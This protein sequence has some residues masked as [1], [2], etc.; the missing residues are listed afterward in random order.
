MVEDRDFFKSYIYGARW[1]VDDPTPILE[2]TEDDRLRVA[3]KL[4][5]SPEFNQQ[6]GWSAFCQNYPQVAFDS[7]VK[8]NLTPENGALWNQFL[9]GLVFGDRESKAIRDD[10]AI[11]TLSLIHI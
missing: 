8:E 10:L 7:L 9:G 1:V 3:R 2:A 5:H 11:Q 4:A 6:Q